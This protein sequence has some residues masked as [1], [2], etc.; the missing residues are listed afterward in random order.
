MVSKYIPLLIPTKPKKPLSSAGSA[1]KRATHDKERERNIWEIKT[2]LAS[3]S[4][5]I[6][7]LAKLI[8]KDHGLSAH[9]LEVANSSYFGLRKHVE[10]VKDAVLILGL[11]A[12]RRYVMSEP[13]LT[14]PA[15]VDLQTSVDVVVLPESRSNPWSALFGEISQAKD[16]SDTVQNTGFADTERID[17]VHRRT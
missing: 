16:Y 12:T 7:Y 8:A 10:T 9:L 5:N 11:D 17:P 15:Q 4:V 14:Q 1:S 13:S 3:D 6:N 2:E